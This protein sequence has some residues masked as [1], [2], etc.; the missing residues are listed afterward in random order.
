MSIQD[1]TLAH[2]SGY[3]EEEVQPVCELMLDYLHR[4]IAHE[5]FFKKY[6]N[7]KFLKGMS[8]W[9]Q[10]QMT[11]SNICPKH[12]YC[13]GNGQ[14]SFMPC[15]AMMLALRLTMSDLGRRLSTNDSFYYGVPQTCWPLSRSRHNF[16]TL[17]TAQ[18]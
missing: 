14:K 11:K 3:T 15:R 16:Q 10:Q 9:L 7:R 13:P 2:Y 18:T 4:P 1:A 6:A 17:K 12:P 5:A 8:T